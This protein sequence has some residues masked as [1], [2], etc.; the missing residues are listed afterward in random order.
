MPRDPLFIVA[1]LALCVV[2]SEW[3]VRRTWLR[4]LGTALVVIV[5]TAVVANLGII[6]T[7]TGDV[8]LY[9]VLFR[10]VAWMA[11]F[12]ML[13]QV[14]LRE[15]VKAGPAMIALF[16]LGALGTSLGALAGMLAI[17]GA[18]HFGEVHAVLAG[19][20]TGTYT[21]GS[22]NFIAIASQYE[23]TDGLL[24]ASANAVDATM[25]AVWMA[26]TVVIPR[27]LRRASGARGGRPAAPAGGPVDDVA[28]DTEGLHPVDLGLV[29]GLGAFAVWGSE[30][31]AVWL[32][33]RLGV[34][35]PGILIL[36]TLALVL[37]QVP[38]IGRLRGPRVLGLFGVYLFLAVIGA[39]CDV[40]ALRSSGALGLWLFV[41][42]TLLLAVHA[43]VVFGA[44][45]LLRLDPDVA[46][47]AS[48]ANI[49]GSTSALALARSLGRAD[50]VLPGILV[51]SLGNAVGTYLGVAV[52]L[53]LR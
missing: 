24:L 12:C 6:P 44:S 16:L 53:I 21:G 13:L 35:I 25:T 52:V 28:D 48:Q 30:S 50:L 51:G 29:L 46:A 5:V 7:G 8:P 32:S 39:L 19:M 3:I 45:T 47:V 22:A 37:A 1:V 41:F 43:A 42:V 10:E 33:G 31:A 14:H 36:T 18:T 9:G 38:A 49:G 27:L 4:H 26:A 15:V 20:F 34:E 17:G 23:V 2:L 11:I 40:E